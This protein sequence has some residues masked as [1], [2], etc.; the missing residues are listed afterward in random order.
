MQNVWLL[1]TCLTNCGYYSTLYISKRLKSDIKAKQ[2]TWLGKFNSIMFFLVKACL[3][4]I[5]KYYYSVF[6]FIK[7][8]IKRREMLKTID[9]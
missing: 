8:G 5:F 4:V 1:Q 2:A 9:Y 6:S 7:I 3:V